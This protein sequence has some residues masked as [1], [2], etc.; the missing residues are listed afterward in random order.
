MPTEKMPDEI[1]QLLVVLVTQAWV[2][3]HHDPELQHN[4]QELDVA[5]KMLSGTDTAVMVERAYPSRHPATDQAGKPVKVEVVVPPVTFRTD[6]ATGE[7]WDR[8]GEFIATARAAI[9][10]DLAFS[11]IM[12]RVAR[13]LRRDLGVEGA[14]Q[15]FRGMI[16]TMAA[17]KEGDH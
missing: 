11:V 1:R 4:A 8:M 5:L 12:S 3:I 7:W 13:E 2:R 9:G 10:D 16:D 14:K 17:A 15:V 6:A